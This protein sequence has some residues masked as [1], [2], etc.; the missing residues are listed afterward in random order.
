[1]SVIKKITFGTWGGWLGTVAFGVAASFVMPLAAQAQEGSAKNVIVMITD[2]ASPGT[3][4]AA[5]YFRHATLGREAYDK[6]DVKMFASTIPYNT[7]NTPTKS[8]EN[9]VTLDTSL[10]WDD[11]PV[12]TVYEGPILGNY[13]GYFAGYDYLRKDYTESSAAATALASGQKTYMKAINWSNNDTRL[14]HIGEYAVQSGRSLGSISSV[15]WSHATPAGFLAHNAD[16]NNYA[17]IGKEVI[18]SGLATV[19]MGGGHPYWYANGT[20]NENPKDDDFRYVGGRDSW[21]RLT[22]GQTE[23]AHIETKEDFEALAAGNLTL[24]GKTKVIGTVQNMMTLQYNR[25]NV[26]AGNFLT[27]VPDLPTMSLAALNVLE[28]ND[29]GFFLMIEGGAVDWA[30]HGNNLPRLIEEQID[31]NLAIEAV[32]KWVEEKSSWDETLVIVTTDHGNG[33]LQGPD[34]HI[35]A[36]SPVVNQGAGALPLVRWHTDHHTREL[37]PLYA[38]GAGADYFTQ[39]AIKEPGLAIYNVSE[40]SQFYVDN[41]DVFRASMY[42]FGLKED[43]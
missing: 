24:N 39:N 17:E 22:S 33:L 31:F 4:D 37:I 16:R 30:A 7:S 21:E 25:P 29:K 3:W 32:V 27:N 13:P 5:S 26:T 18:D 1:M 40:E 42:A 10:M 9:R 34:S 35:N 12:D 36:Y 28:K 15:M 23:Y 41:T 6:F 11:T 43:E 14:K 20:R 19:V 2:G 38:H 8:D